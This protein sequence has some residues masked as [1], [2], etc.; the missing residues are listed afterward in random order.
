MAGVDATETARQTRSFVGVS[1]GFE[2]NIIKSPLS[3]QDAKVR[4][5]SNTDQPRSPRLWKVGCM[6]WVEIGVHRDVTEQLLVRSTARPVW[7]A[8]L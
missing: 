8:V 3:I 4:I 6:G 2:N 7:K 1:P 5:G